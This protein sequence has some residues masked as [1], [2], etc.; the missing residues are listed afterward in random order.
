MAVKTEEKKE[1]LT[2]EMLAKSTG[3]DTEK[4]SQDLEAEADALLNQV[5]NPEE[6]EAEEEKEEK[7]AEE[8]KAEEK[9]E[10]QKKE[11][12]SVAAPEE[13]IVADGDDTIESLIEKLNKSE[14]R[15]KDNQSSFTKN[16]QKIQTERT[17][18]KAAISALNDKI[19]DLQQKIIDR[20]QAES[21]KEVR[22]ADKDINKSVTD[23]KDQFEVLNRVDPDIAK[24]IQ[25]II[26]KLTGEIT[27][28]KSDLKN[29]EVSDTK[30]AQQIADEKHFSA[31]DSAHPG[32]EDTMNSLEFQTY[33]DGLS[34]RQKNLVEFDLKQGSSANII[35][36][37]SD[38]KEYSGD[39]EEEDETTAGNTA[40]EEMLKK[41][42]KMANPDLKKSKQIKTSATV[43]Y[44]RQMIK[45]NMNDPAWVEKH[46]ADIDVELAAGR[47]PAR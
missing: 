23:L 35:E 19:S 34:P 43:K 14:K 27:G 40:N 47:I 6:A 10:E 44:T 26:E 31:I 41:A 46:Q 9:Q 1:E 36:I 17:E 21:T 5:Y 2:E 37:F 13:E 24:P 15:V 4:Y 11:E 45:D 18:S 32:W 42:K 20:P 8:K 22:E 7:P 28:L 38:F 12:E 33:K 16:Q 39:T 30:T 25:E 29:K 3:P